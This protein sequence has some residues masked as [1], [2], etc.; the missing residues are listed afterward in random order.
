MKPNIIHYRLPR[1]AALLAVLLVLASVILPAAPL[2]AQAGAAGQPGADALVEADA[3]GGVQITWRSPGATTDAAQAALPTV[4]YQ[5]YDLP[6]RAIPVRLAG[7][8]QLAALQLQR[9]DAVD[10]PPGSVT[11]GAP[12]APPVDDNEGRL[13]IL[14]QPEPAL[15]TAP[16]F[17]V[18]SGTVDGEFIAVLGVSPIY[19]ENGVLRLATELEAF[20]PGATRVVEGAARSEAAAAAERA[21]VAASLGGASAA[22]AEASTA[23]VKI[24]VAAPGIQRVP[25]TALQAVVPGVAAADLAKA[26][27]TVNGAVV[28]VQVVGS[29][30]RF[31]APTAGDRWNT[32]SAYLLGFP[33]TVADRSPAMVVR[34]V[35]A[36][37]GAPSTALQRGVWLGNRDDQ[38]RPIR[39]Y[40]SIRAGADGDHWFA[41]DLVCKAGTQACSNSPKD[42]PP[43][44]AADLQSDPSRTP[45]TVLPLA[46]GTSTF[47][48][49]LSPYQAYWNADQKRFYLSFG[50]TADGGATWNWPNVDVSYGTA[51]RVRLYANYD[52]V[53]TAPA[54]VQKLT[55]SLKPLA[56]DGGVKLDSIVF[57]R[58]V[59]LIFG[60]KGAAFSGSASQTT[61][62]WAEAK[63]L[64]GYE[65]Y[66]VSEAARPAV[67]TGAAAG[68]FTDTQAARSYLLAGETTLFLPTVEKLNSYS[69][70]SQGAHAIYIVPDGAYADKL[71]PL[72]DWRA[73]QGYTT[74]VVPVSRIYDTYSYGQIAPEGIRRFL[75]YA[76]ANWTPQP[77][78]AVLV[79]DGTWDVRNYAHKS[80]VPALIPPYM[81]DGIDPWIG[82]APCDNCYG[83]LHGDDPHTGDGGTFDTELQIGRLPVKSPDELA[84]LVH[85]IV[86]YEST[87]GA[88]AAQEGA[89]A[90][91]V[92]FYADNHRK[93]KPNV[94]GCQPADGYTP[95]PAGDF[96]YLSDRLLSEVGPAARTQRVYYDPFPPAG[97]PWREPNTNRLGERL[98]A[99]MNAGP[100]VAVYNGHASTWHMGATE[101]DSAC[102]E[103]D[104]GGQRYR[105]AVLNLYEETRLNNATQLFVQLSMTCLTSQF[106][107][108][109]DAGTT[110]DERLL[111]HPSGGAVAVWGPAGLSVIHGHDL[112][113]RG[114]FEALFAAPDQ[115]PRVGEL[116]DAGYETV[117][118]AGSGTEDV[119]RTFLLLGDPL[120]R[121]H[122]N[123]TS[124]TFLPVVNK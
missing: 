106:A 49:R 105:P 56:G 74:R 73:Q 97:E 123:S 98:F 99:A 10:L 15:P 41:A 43:T 62:A 1:P 90:H 34:A 17:V 65:L 71:Q 48:V 27:L 107:I 58:P 122:F 16:V 115:T 80:I 47:T 46:A 25:L 93:P 119:L 52:H 83:Q 18:R 101:R 91:R 44:F 108:P 70:G 89:P 76:Y 113:Q 81:H 20:L 23:Q 42:P 96:A 66:D 117:R 30:L 9:L 88:G 5:G 32:T 120:T 11:P 69:V 53:F 51:P 6:L 12:D 92:L 57:V 104:T 72:L 35:S 7:P 67:L 31:Y 4:R 110:I 21:G 37:S 19:A 63:A 111:L 45:P 36:A 82:E 54:Q 87:A 124:S 60:Q 94:A 55:F 38:Q 95:D 29:E 28:A 61:Y 109:A 102:E 24:Q 50:A 33:E 121:L 2:H 59:K 75:Q 26:R 40:A 13:D 3:A 114:F 116:L 68:G 8:E 64:N 84:V 22:A 14:P 86:G 77:I 85:K 100:D 78:A 103:P 118:R 79:G 39:L 112:L